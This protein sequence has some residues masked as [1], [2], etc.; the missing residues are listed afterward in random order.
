MIGRQVTGFRRALIHDDEIATGGTIEELTRL[1]LDYGLQE[2][3]VICTHGLFLRGALERLADVP[4]I[5]EIITTDTVPQRQH[6]KLVVLSTG[7]VFA[8]AMRQNYYR[9][10][11]GELFDFGDGDLDE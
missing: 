10:S 4:Q 9:Q 7:S 1:L 2:I 5:C 6:D 3:Y 11:I 8:G